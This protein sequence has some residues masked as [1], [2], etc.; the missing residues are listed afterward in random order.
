M[1][2]VDITTVHTGD[3]SRVYVLEFDTEHGHVQAFG[4]GEVCYYPPRRGAGPVVESGA[5]G[6]CYG[7][8]QIIGDVPIW[9]AEEHYLAIFPDEPSMRA[10]GRQLAAAW[11]DELPVGVHRVI[12]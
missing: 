7:E 6:G 12:G 1:L 4:E 9:N 8:P 11:G 2:T 5:T 3:A 10:G